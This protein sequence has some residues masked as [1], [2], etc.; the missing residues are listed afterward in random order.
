MK[1]FIVVITVVLV[2]GVIFLWHRSSPLRHRSSPPTDAQISQDINGA[3]QQE[4]GPLQIN[5]NANGS[6]SSRG[7]DSKSTSKYGGTWVVSNGLLT[8][9]QTNSE[10]DG[11]VAA[12][13][14][15]RIKSI[16]KH[17]ISIEQLVDG[18]GGELTVTFF[19]LSNWLTDT[20]ADSPLHFGR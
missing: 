12:I 6:F 17:H 14:R 1:K 20:V 19:P 11:Q 13:V 9:M 8:L 16:D 3:W 18:H 5:F 15:F 10:P 2:I 4:V 7:K